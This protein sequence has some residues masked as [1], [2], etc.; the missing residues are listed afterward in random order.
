MT[1]TYLVTLIDIWTEKVTL[2]VTE[3]QLVTLFDNLKW[4]QLKNTIS[5]DKQPIASAVNHFMHIWQIPI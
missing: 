1:E 3:T 5:S 4:N 2:I